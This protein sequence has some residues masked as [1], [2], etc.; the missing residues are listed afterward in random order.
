MC[1]IDLGGWS[2]CIHIC[3][4]AYTHNTEH[5]LKKIHH[6]TQARKRESD[7]RR[8]KKIKFTPKISDDL[9]LLLPPNSNNK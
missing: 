5:A 3:I 9:S 4:Y 7:N 1:T 8:T 6:Y 2:P